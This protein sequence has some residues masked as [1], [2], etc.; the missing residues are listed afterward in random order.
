MTTFPL[1]NLRAGK[2]EVDMSATTSDNNNQDIPL[3]ILVK[4]GYYEKLVLEIDRRDPNFTILAVVSRAIISHNIDTVNLED[5]TGK[6]S[7][8]GSTISSREA[9]RKRTAAAGNTA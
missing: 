2:E 1:L 6:D 5:P 3:E 9:K 8:A 7:L 4:P